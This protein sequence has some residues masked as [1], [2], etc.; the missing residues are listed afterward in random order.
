[1]RDAIAF[2]SWVRD[3][4]VVATFRNHHHFIEQMEYIVPRRGDRTCNPPMGYITVYT[5]PGPYLQGV[6]SLTILW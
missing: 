5:W 6:I 1:M 4:N 2:W 3:H